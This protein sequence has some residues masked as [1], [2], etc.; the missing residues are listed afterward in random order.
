MSYNPSHFS[1]C[2]GD[3][4]VESVSWYEAAAY[5]NALS[6][7]EGLE[8]CYDCTGSAPDV[9]CSSA[10]AFASPYDCT[11]YRLPTDAEWEFA[12][13]A[14]TTTATYNGDLDSDHLGCETPNPVLDPIAWFC[15][16][17]G[18]TTHTVDELAPNAW[19]LYDMLGNLVEWCHDWFQDDLGVEPVIDPFGPESGSYKLLRGGSWLSSAALVRAARRA[20]GNLDIHRDYI[21]FRT[22]KTLP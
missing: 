19:G 18:E 21:G 10:A 7:S 12:A 6:D 2:G 15:G 14:G 17:S 3:C 13:R 22:A 5:C 20:W 16:N 4:P 11:G 8:R 9:T 1:A